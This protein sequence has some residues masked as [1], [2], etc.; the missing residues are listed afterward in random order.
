MHEIVDMIRKDKIIAIIRGLEKGNL[1]PVVEALV[2]GGIR[3][4]EI[5]F[6]QRGAP[7]DTAN[8]IRLVAQNYSGDV[9]VGAGTVMTT[10]QLAAA[11]AAGANYIISPNVNLEVIHETKRSGLV[12]IP[13]ALTPSEIACA[14]ENGADFVKV[15]PA[16][17]MGLEYIKAIRAPVSNIPLLAVG[18][19]YRGQ[20]RR[21][22]GGGDRWVWDWLQHCK[23]PVGA[24][25]KV[26]GNHQTRGRL[27]RERPPSIKRAAEWDRLVWINTGSPCRIFG[28][29]LDTADQALAVARRF[30]ALLG[31]PVKEG[32]SSAFTGR[33]IEVMKPPFLRDKKHIA[34]YTAD[35]PAAARHMEEQGCSPD[36]ATSKRNTEGEVTSA[37]LPEESRA[38]PST[39]SAMT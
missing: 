26:R 27:P 38:L 28:L 33:E 4:I 15:F 6:D 32:N 36:W 39:C 12:S 11:I 10:A 19:D 5:T 14:H 8:A 18:G 24:A 21:L 25:G 9:C 30:E 34:I 29:N 13:G 3:L 31:F 17:A 22:Y 35:I 7:E 1:A 2:R 23:K 16:S 20:H 37:C